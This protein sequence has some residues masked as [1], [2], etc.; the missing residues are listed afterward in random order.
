MTAND[1]SQAYSKQLV[2]H[3]TDAAHHVPQSVVAGL[4]YGKCLLPVAAVASFCF[5]KQELFI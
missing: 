5:K 4:S 2:P 3:R 1:K